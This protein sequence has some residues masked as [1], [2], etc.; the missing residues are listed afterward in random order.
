[1][2]TFIAWC[3]FVGAWLLVAGPLRQASRELEEE[4]LERDALDHAKDT[5]VRPESISPWWW[6]LPPVA[7]FLQRKRSDEYR[8]RVIAAMPPEQQRAF[9]SF[10]DK[11]AT[12]MFVAGG[13]F[14][15]A[16]KETW[17]LREANEWSDTAF[18]V[19]IFVMGAICVGNAIASARQRHERAPAGNS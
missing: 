10:H 3:G 7:Y 1:V 2:H 9:A 17:E 4:E 5:V 12:W 15:I 6:L 16:V 11:A 19:L 18:W 8:Q 14:L 13:A